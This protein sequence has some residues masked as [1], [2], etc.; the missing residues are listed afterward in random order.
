MFL[1]REEC[2]MSFATA[3]TKILL[4]DGMTICEAPSLGLGFIHD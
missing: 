4:L 2:Q 1:G 3:S